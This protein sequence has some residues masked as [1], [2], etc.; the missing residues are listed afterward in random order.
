MP[1]LAILSR[2]VT[3]LKQRLL[4]LFQK[5]LAKR[6]TDESRCADKTSVDNSFNL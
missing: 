4:Y 5:N 6:I 1:L 2:S 3:M